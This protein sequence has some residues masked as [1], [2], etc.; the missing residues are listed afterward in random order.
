MFQQL[1]RRMLRPPAFGLDISDLSIKFARIAAERGVF[2]L[3]VFGEIEV[4]AGVI[5]GGEIQNES[6]LIRLLRAGLRSETGQHVRERFCVASLPEE[7]SFVHILELPPNIHGED[8]GNAVRWEVEGVVPLPITEMYY[9]YEPFGKGT[10]DHQDVLLIAFPRSIIDSYHRVLIAGGFVPLALELE[11]QSVSRA[12]IKSGAPTKPTIIMDIGATRTSF[13]L[14]AGGSLVFTKS[15]PVGGRELEQAI[16]AALG[17]PLEQARTVKIEAGLNRGMRDGKVFAALAP[18]LGTIA[19]ELEQQLWFYRDHTA[20][21]HR[22][23]G[24]VARVMLCGGDANLIGLEQYLSAAVRRETAVGNPFINVAIP[25]GSVPPIPKNL[26]LKYTTALGLG[27][28]A[29]AY[30]P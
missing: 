1:T 26:S 9:D 19:T 3:D 7:K 15:I 4:P 8:L 18:E 21:Q 29:A 20:S 16:A 25:A 27:L 22:D 23:W 17:I 24:D 10:T 12:L 14:F 11:S 28:R 13:I 2:R 5:N 30:M 6:E